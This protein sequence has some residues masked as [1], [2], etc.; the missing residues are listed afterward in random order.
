MQIHKRMYES[1][2]FFQGK[3]KSFIAWV[4]P[5]LHPMSINESEYIYKEGEEITESKLKI[6]TVIF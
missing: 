5:M 4:G 2:K 1:V 6:L 3:D